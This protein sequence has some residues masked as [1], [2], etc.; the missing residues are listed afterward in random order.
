MMQLMG[1]YTAP[2][3]AITAEYWT[4]SHSNVPI[5]I[6]TNYAEQIRAAEKYWLTCAITAT[7]FLAV[8]SFGGWWYQRRLRGIFRRLV[9]DLGIASMDLEEVRATTGPF[10]PVNGIQ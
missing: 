4:R 8:V 1:V 5:I 10:S 6:S 2:K 9:D 3:C 7:I